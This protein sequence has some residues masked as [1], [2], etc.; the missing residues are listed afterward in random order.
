MFVT[1]MSHIVI[2]DSNI[3]IHLYSYYYYSNFMKKS[4]ARVLMYLSQV[5]ITEAYL[6]K[7][8]TKLDMDYGYLTKVMKVMEAKEWILRR[9]S[10]SKNK[11]KVFYVLTL[12]GKR[13]MLAAAKLLTAGGNK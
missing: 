12:T 7:I 4:E 8:S 1:K 6:M 5:P 9:K 3:T 2:Y 13:Q 11:N 10:F